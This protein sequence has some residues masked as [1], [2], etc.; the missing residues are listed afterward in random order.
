M[1][2]IAF[3]VGSGTTALDVLLSVGVPY[4]RS[5]HITLASAHLA[6]AGCCRLTMQVAVLLGP[7]FLAD[8]LIILDAHVW[9]RPWRCVVD[10]CAIVVP[11]CAALLCEGPADMLRLHLLLVLPTLLLWPLLRRQDEALSP[12][13]IGALDKLNGARLPALTQLRG[14]GYVQLSFVILA[15]DFPLLP[16]RHAKTLTYGKSF[17]D[18]GVGGVICISALMQRWR[19]SS[20]ARPPTGTRRLSLVFLRH[21]PLLMLGAGRLMAVRL[22]DYHEVHSEYGTHWNFFFTLGIVAAAAAAA[23]P[24]NPYAAAVAGLSVLL[25]HQAALSGG[26]AAYV[27]HAPRLSLISANKE[28]LASL[29]GYIGLWL[30]ADGTSGILL[31]PR[32]SFAEWWRSLT[33][34]CAAALV[35]GACT[36]VIEAIIGQGSSRRLCNLPYALWTLSMV[37]LCL[38]ACLLTS[39]IR[40]VDPPPPLLTAI[41]T[42][43]LTI[44]L[45]ANLLTGAVNLS[46]PT[47]GM[48]DAPAA[49]VLSTYM[50]VVCA[51]AVAL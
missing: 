32:A 20:A 28:G 40:P 23:T 14:T 16:R 2:K 39:L 8:R 50:A 25:A 46:M 19:V 4:V 45:A 15:V 51:L 33:R 44:F 1:A 24:A 12:R 13:A 6:H 38:C 47:M 10:F 49:A 21:L 18:L 5:A 42:R 34:L 41:S 37:L 3:G 43:P 9:S 22:S 29:A 7:W 30:L 48:A 31:R 35:L 11:A 26:L 17:M 36:A 27:E